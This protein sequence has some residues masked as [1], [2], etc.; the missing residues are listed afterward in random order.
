M[1]L[2]GVFF[3]LAIFMFISGL[4]RMRD[5]L[6]MFTL[7]SLL[8]VLLLW[9]LASVYATS[10]VAI[11][12]FCHE[13]RPCV[14]HIMESS[15]NLSGDISNYYLGCVYNETN[16]IDPYQKPLKVGLPIQS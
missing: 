14:K 16:R 15:F 8:S 4:C 5:Y 1:G 2:L 10:A 12:D 11:A 3:L 9:V 7:C 13:P 6:V